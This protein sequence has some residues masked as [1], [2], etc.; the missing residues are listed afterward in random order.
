MHTSRS[1][2][3]GLF[4]LLL[5]MFMTGS[6]AAQDATP[7]ATPGGPPEGY[8]VAIHQGSCA[9][10][11]AQPASDLGNAT[12]PGTDQGG[13]VETIGQQA[14]PILLVSSSTVEIALDDLGAQPHVI[15]VHASPDDYETIVACGQ[16]G[17]IK[18]DGRIAFALEPV[19]SSTTVG[20]AI[21]EEDDDQVQ[22][23]VYV[24]DTLPPAEST[25][26]SWRMRHGT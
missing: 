23:T 3:L 10:P 18:A 8:P 25:P 22:S 1:T 9:E 5:G 14:G 15:A 24:F 4:T 26:V 6:A 2:F 13:E 12:A 11:T 20:V 16:I 17:G 21:L 7:A 19:G